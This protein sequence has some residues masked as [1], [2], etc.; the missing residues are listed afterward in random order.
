MDFTVCHIN[1]GAIAVDHVK[2]ASADEALEQA[3][4]R[5][6]IDPVVFAGHIVAQASA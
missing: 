4:Q 5:G 3:Q 6:L 2:A 1:H